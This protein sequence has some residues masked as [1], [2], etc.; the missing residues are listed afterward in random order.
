MSKFVSG[1]K[2]DRWTY[3]DLT[4]RECYFQISQEEGF[5][6]IT[7]Y[8]NINNYPTFDNDGNVSGVDTTKSL[9]K[10]NIKGNTKT[11]FDAYETLKEL[12]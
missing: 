2:T 1:L 5:K 7:V 10:I 6:D 3:S 9:V 11:I 12:A 8:V 4:F